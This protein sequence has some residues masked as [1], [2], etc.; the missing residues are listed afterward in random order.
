MSLLLLFNSTGDGPTPT[1][2]SELTGGLF[3]AWGNLADRATVY[4]G[5]W[6]DGL[7][8]SNL[9][10]R[11]RSRVARSLTSSPSDTCFIVDLG[12]VAIWRLFALAGHNIS[13]DGRV[14]VRAGNDPTFA[15]WDYDT[16]WQAVWPAVYSTEALEWEADNFWSGAYTER[17]RQ[18][19][20][21]DIFV[22]PPTFLGA[23]YIKVEIDDPLNQA[24]FVQAARLMVADGWAP[25]RGMAYTPQFRVIDPSAVQT[26]SSGAESYD[27]KQRLREASFS[28]NY[29]PESEAYGRGFELQREAGIT[30]EVAFIWKDDD[31]EQALRRRFI[32]RLDE[33]SPIDHPL[34]DPR[35]MAFKVRE[36]L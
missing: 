16:E 9:K 29:L 35:S 5:G 2:P 26:A 15:S 18:G 22:R 34:P 19:L 3:M 24:S 4:G 17:Q 32:G 14:R 10:I 20:S 28:L 8:L 31:V 11:R 30:G 12:A 7:P 23:R 27:V 13:L 1:P 21:W 33:L 25:S 36:T 6:R